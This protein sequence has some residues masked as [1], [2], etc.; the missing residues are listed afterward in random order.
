[1]N[2]PTAHYFVLNG[3]TLGYTYE[4]N[5][6]WFNILHASVLRGSTFDRL[7]GPVP[8]GPRDVLV[9]AT[10]A[11]FDAFRCVPPRGYFPA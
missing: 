10:Q 5:E 8:L 2:M 4:G 1:M 6:P 3:H 7:S 9:P 11:D